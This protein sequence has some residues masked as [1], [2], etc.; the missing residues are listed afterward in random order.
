MIDFLLGLFEGVVI[1]GSIGCFIGWFII[2]KTGYHEWM[3][4][5]V[6]RKLWK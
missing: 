6:E 4:R 2:T 1:G 3:V 5:R